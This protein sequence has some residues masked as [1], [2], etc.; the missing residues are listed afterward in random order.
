MV[1]LPHLKRA[2]LQPLFTERAKISADRHAGL[3]PSH[4]GARLNDH[5]ADVA[6]SGGSCSVR[7]AHLIRL[8]GST[9]ASVEAFW[10][11][12]DFFQQVGIKVDA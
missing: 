9:I 2:P 7:G 12:L 11:N 8:S 4:S 5:A 6:P 1:D 10:D 3:R